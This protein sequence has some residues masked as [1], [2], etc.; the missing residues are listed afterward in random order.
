MTIQKIFKYNNIETMKINLGYILIFIT[1][2]CTNLSAQQKKIALLYPQNTIAL[3]SENTLWLTDNFYRWELFLIQNKYKY[4][5]IIDDDLEDGLS[6]EYTLLIL[7]AAKCLTENEI[8]SIKE[9]MNEG[10]SIL[11]TLGIGVF[12]PVGKWK[13]W[14]DLEQI[15]G[16]SFVSEITQKE[17]SRIHTLFGATPISSNIPPGFRLQI[18]TYDKPVEVRIMSEN[19]F[20]LGYWQNSI[21]PFEGK[22]KIDNTTSAVFG[23]YGKGNFV[24]LGF[25]FSAVVGAK[26]HQKTSNQL[27]KNIIHWLTDELV[28]QLE[29]WPNGKQ[30]AAVLSCDVEFKFN[31]INNALD[32]LEQENLP[33][34]FYILTEA[35]DYPSFERLKKVGDVGL[36]GDDHLLFK[37]QDHNSQLSRLSNGIIT[38]EK[39]MGRKPIAFRP[40]ETFYDK[41]TLDAMDALSLNILASDNIEDRAVP[42]FLES[43][44]KLL[45]IPKTGFDD[46]DIFQ[47][48]KIESINE[49]A[50]RYILDFNRTHEEGGLYSLNFH[51]QMQCLKEFVDALIQPIQE[52]KSK[53]VWITTHNHVYDWWLKKNKL[54][55]KTKLIGDKNYIVEI[56]NGGEADIDDVVLSLSKK[57]FSDLSTI[58]IMLDGRSL[59]YASDFV[60]QKIKVAVPVIRSKETKLV[61]ISF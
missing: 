30:S 32:L 49:Q 34:Q 44:P 59:D 33:S 21:I 37:W 57:N 17:G 28:V 19:T 23:N 46:Y 27:F 40:P 53:D 51:T 41:V 9:F 3:P 1:I 48:L 13:G 15:F 2:F 12:D 31:Y 22:N 25:E 52:I 7:P 5:I 4:E 56:E 6:D 35:I 42:Q 55:L 10:N 8:R 26:E 50:N 60:T 36:H 11:S 61:S 16:V 58:E 29:T 43:H 38:L 39:G 20:P 54:E 24:W 14:G 18:T 45:V 47:R